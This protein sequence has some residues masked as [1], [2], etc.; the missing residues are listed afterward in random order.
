MGREGGAGRQRQD[1]APPMVA[2]LGRGHGCGPPP[3]SGSD[4]TAHCARDQPWTISKLSFYSPICRKPLLDQM[5]V[6]G[7]LNSPSWKKHLKKQVYHESPGWTVPT[8]F[9]QFNFW[10]SVIKTRTSNI[11]DRLQH[12]NLFNLLRP[13]FYFIVYFATVE[14]KINHDQIC[15]FLKWQNIQIM[16]QR[17]LQEKKK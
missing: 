13:G 16:S 1:L 3:P 2:G 17:K 9:C 7:L 4:L 12:H 10:K 8:C 11:R 5:T 15:I 14:I 6:Y